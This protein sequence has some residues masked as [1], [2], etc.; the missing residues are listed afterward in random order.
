MDNEDKPELNLDRCIG[1]GVCAS[2][3][4]FDAIT[5]V[6]RAGILTPPLDQT[7]LREAIKA[8]QV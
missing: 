8:S 4:A 7:T 2:G 5:L 1:C 6:E 3:C